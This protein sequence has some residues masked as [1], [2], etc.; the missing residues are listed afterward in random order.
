LSHVR[1]TF[2][3]VLQPLFSC[4]YHFYFA[5]SLEMEARVYYISMK[6]I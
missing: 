6:G 5:V 2:T 3:A 1:D 4:I